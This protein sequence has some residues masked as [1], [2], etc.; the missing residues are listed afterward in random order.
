LKIPNESERGRSICNVGGIGDP[1]AHVAG[2]RDSMDRRTGS[3]LG[4][5]GRER[6]RREGVAIDTLEVTFMKERE[7]KNHNQNLGE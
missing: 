1:R 4:V 3:R 7:S 2:K 6:E 5:D